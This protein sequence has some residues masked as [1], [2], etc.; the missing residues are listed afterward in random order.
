MN[1]ITAYQTVDSDRIWHLVGIERRGHPTLD[2]ST[3]T[4]VW[5]EIPYHNRCLTCYRFEHE[6]IPRV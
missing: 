5:E 4:G 1:L 6:V 3:A 2:D